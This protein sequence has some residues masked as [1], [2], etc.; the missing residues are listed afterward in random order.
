MN[1]AKKVIKKPQKP[2]KLQKVGN[3]KIWIITSIVLVV[4]LIG[5]LSFDQLYK[6]TVLTINDEKYSME[7]LSYYFYGVEAKYDFMNQIY[8]GNY[9]NMVEESTGLTYGDLAQQEVIS[10]ALISEILYFDAVKNN[11]ELTEEEKDTI[12]SD[13]DS[14]FT[15]EA[16]K[17]LIKHNDYT[18][19]Y[20]THILNRTTLAERYRRDII[21]SLNIDDEAIKAEINFEDYRQYDIEYLYVSTKTMDAVGNSID[22]TE[23]EKKTALDKINSVLEAAKTTQEWST[24]VPEDEEVLDYTDSS[25]TKKDDSFSEDFKTKVM[26]MKN[27]EVSE[28][29]ETDGEYYIVRMKNNNSTESYDTEVNSAISTAENEAFAPKYQEI[30]KNYEYKVNEKE[31]SNYR[32]GQITLP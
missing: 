3:P 17:E 7:D 6:R 1:S 5:A 31:L 15:E 9:Y 27:D 8:S 23:E 10:S 14:F 21:D 22:K 2:S 24:L 32:M 11:Y 18:K 4:L 26:A 29:I 20:I 25:F 28:I 12:A 13:V 19:K 30:A 16:N